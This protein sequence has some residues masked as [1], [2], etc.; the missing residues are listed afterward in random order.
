MQDFLAL[1][2]KVIGAIHRSTNHFFPLVGPGTGATNTM[3]DPTEEAV[4]AIKGM[5]ITHDENQIREALWR[6]GNNPQEACAPS[7][8]RTFELGLWGGQ[9]HT[10]FCS[11]TLGQLSAASYYMS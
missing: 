3:S 9:M 4:E 2:D 11:L 10:A 6:C 7:D 8:R 1:G 5:G